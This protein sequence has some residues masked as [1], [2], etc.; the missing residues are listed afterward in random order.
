[1]AIHRFFAT[2][3][4]MKRISWKFLGKIQPAKRPLQATRGPVAIPRLLGGL[5]ID[6]SS[7]LCRLE[8]WTQHLACCGVSLM[9]WWLFHGE[10][11]GVD[12]LIYLY[13][14][15]ICFTWGNHGFNDFFFGW[16]RS[17]RKLE[18]GKAILLE[19]GQINQGFLLQEWSRAALQSFL[20]CHPFPVYCRQSFH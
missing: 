8:L 11:S 4:P 6:R 9:I 12:P 19:S 15:D 5:L 10:N 17:I 13:I 20:L 16:I 1:M 14:Y 3:A 7:G 2:I 18:V